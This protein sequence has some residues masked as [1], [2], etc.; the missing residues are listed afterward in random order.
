MKRQYLI[1]SLKERGLTQAELA[2]RIGCSEA[3]V[4]KL[5]GGGHNMTARLLIKMAKAIGVPAPVLL[6]HEA[7]YLDRSGE[8]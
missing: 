1:N 7:N 4:S 3:W 5:I 8:L 2:G 6:K